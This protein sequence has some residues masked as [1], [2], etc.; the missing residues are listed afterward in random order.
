M[1]E[2]PFGHLARRFLAILPHLVIWQMCASKPQ[3][4]QTFIITYIIY[5]IFFGINSAD[6]V[7]D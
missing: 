3:F 4:P 5:S 2:P 7:D 1:R 6:T